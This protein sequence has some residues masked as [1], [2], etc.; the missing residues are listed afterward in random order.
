MALLQLLFTYAPFMN[1]VFHS[2]PLGFMEWILVIGNSL[3][4]F[5]AV[6]TQKWAGRRRVSGPNPL[7]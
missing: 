5:L 7:T 4:I 1:S 6:E 3:I 2:A